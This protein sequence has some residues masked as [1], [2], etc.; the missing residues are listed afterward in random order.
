MVAPHHFSIVP[1]LL[2]LIHLQ[3]I[4]GDDIFTSIAHLR[5]LLLNHDIFKVTIEN[6]IRLEEKRLLNIKDATDGQ[7]YRYKHREDERLFA[8]RR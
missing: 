3:C 8:I 5:K 6:Y 7:Q 1:F 2:I 4:G